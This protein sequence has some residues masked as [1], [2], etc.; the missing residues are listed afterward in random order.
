MTQIREKLFEST[1]N[2]MLI[3]QVRSNLTK[4]TKVTPAQ[5][6]KYFD[7]MPEDSLPFIPTKMEVQILVRKPIISQ[8]EIDRVKDELRSYTDRVNKGE[9]QFSTLALLYSEDKA[10]AQKGGELG[11]L[12]RHQLVPEFSAVAFNLT[13]PKVVSKIVETE[14]GFHIIQ[15]IEKRGDRMNVRHILKR[16]R[17]S[18]ESL[19][20]CIAQVDSIVDGVRKGD[21]TFEEAAAQTS[22]DVETRANNG[23]M[24]YTPSAYMKTS[25]FELQNLPSEVAKQVA[26]MAVGDISK[27]FVMVNDKGRE[28]VAVVRLKNKI[29]GHRATMKSDYQDL[30][31]VVED[32]INQEKV[33]KWV[34]EMQ[35]KTYIR[36]NENWRNCEFKY[37]GW[38]HE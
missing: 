4:D 15:L 14:Y 32:K 9:T 3:S 19:T 37:P 26:N 12:S 17:V 30:Q 27:P 23:L 29:N 20:A 1:K 31:A 35:K 34:R 7:N 11:F 16:P 22:E 25:K 24:T 5:V 18:D 6:R 33:D 8:E 28:V 13:D 2:E 36:I 21:Y 10:S 38:I